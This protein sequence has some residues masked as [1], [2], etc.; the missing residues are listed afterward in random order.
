MNKNAPFKTPYKKSFFSQDM[1]KLESFE[2]QL[3]F[4][5]ARVKEI[6]II[7]L[8]LGDDV[9]DDAMNESET[10][11]SEDSIDDP[12]EDDFVLKKPKIEKK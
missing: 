10:L 3:H 7:L 6:E 1:E 8:E 5:E 12:L 2:K 4:L 9:I 11:G